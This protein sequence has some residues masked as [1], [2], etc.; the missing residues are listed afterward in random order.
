MKLNIVFY[1][2]AQG[3]YLTNSNLYTP[4]QSNSRKDSHSL[5]VRCNLELCAKCDAAEHKGCS[6]GHWLTAMQLDE[7][8]LYFSL[9][10][11]GNNILLYLNETD[12]LWGSG[13]G[14]R[15]FFWRAVVFD[16][17][18]WFWMLTFV[19]SEEK[20]NKTKHHSLDLYLM[21]KSPIAEYM[22][23]LLLFQAGFVCY[24][25]RV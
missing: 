5:A 25:Q 13:G 12:L 18:Y 17:S 15:F 19:S 24:F 11:K 14:C 20:Q 2:P 8:K 9:T 10:F 6:M 22:Y 4:S 21:F 16:S 3:K 1:S 23:I 7:R